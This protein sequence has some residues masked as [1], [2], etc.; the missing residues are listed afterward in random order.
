LWTWV[1]GAV[2]F[3]STVYITQREARAKKSLRPNA[4]IKESKL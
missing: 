2:I 3:A 4:G 1:G